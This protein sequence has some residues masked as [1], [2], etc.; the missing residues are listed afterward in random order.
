MVV[1]RCIQ[2][3]FDGKFGTRY[4]PGNVA[5]I[6]PENPV[7]KYFVEVEPVPAPVD[8]EGEEEKEDEDED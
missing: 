7:A 2:E 4:F 1:M 5:Q 8:L 6:D 3:C